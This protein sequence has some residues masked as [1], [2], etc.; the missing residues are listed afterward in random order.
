MD[1]RIDVWNDK[2]KT[3]PPCSH[4]S[5]KY[6]WDTDFTIP[7]NAHAHKSKT[8]IS[9]VNAD[10]I[11]V[12]RAFVKYKSLVLNLADDCFPGGCVYTGSGATFFDL[13]YLTFIQYATMKLFTRLVSQCS[14]RVKTW[15]LYGARLS[16][17]TL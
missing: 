14:K 17:S 3:A 8:K 1:R 5:V 16:N 12:G 11:D 15:I 9:V 4:P 2:E 10:L 6:K 7:V 13:F